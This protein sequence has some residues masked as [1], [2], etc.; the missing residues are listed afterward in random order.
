MEYRLELTRTGIDIATEAVLGYMNV[1][2]GSDI[3]PIGYF[4]TAEHGWSVK[5]NVKMYSHFRV[6]SYKMKHSY[7]GKDT[8]RHCLRPL[9]PQYIKVLIHDAW[10]NDPKTLLGCV[11][12]RVYGSEADK[13]SS[14]LAM[15]KLFELLGGYE[16]GRKGITLVVL[17]NFPKERFA[18]DAGATKENW[19]G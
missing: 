9:E 15:N 17:N 4:S 1:Y 16:F 18:K 7:K 8:E 14:K 5:D 12:P 10:R 6:G 19:R 13:A 3:N 2:S 11:A